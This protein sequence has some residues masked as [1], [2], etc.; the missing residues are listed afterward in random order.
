MKKFVGIVNGKT[1]NNEKEFNDAADLAIKSNDGYLLISSYYSED[2]KEETEFNKIKSSSKNETKTLVDNTEYILTDQKPDAYSGYTV[3]PELKTKL[4]TAEN[5]DEI[6]KNIDTLLTKFNELIKETKHR[7]YG[8]EDDIKEMQSRL[9][10]SKDSLTDLNWRVLYYKELMSI[11]DTCD[12]TCERTCDTTC[13]RTCDTT[14]EKDLSNKRQTTIFN[15]VLPV[16][17]NDSL[18]TILKKFGL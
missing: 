14:C 18:Y 8:L 9:N 11:L 6:K 12:T 17:C 4:N 13:E 7:I 5:K 10:E 15:D 2:T 3:S 1:F 16:F